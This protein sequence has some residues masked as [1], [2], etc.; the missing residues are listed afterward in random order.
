MGHWLRADFQSPGG[1]CGHCRGH[2]LVPDCLSG[3]DRSGKTPSGV[4]F[5]CILFKKVPFTPIGFVLT[6]IDYF[7]ITTTN[8]K[9][10]LGNCE[11]N[12]WRALCVFVQPTLGTFLK[13]K[14]LYVYV[15]PP[16]LFTS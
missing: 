5:F 9:L 13:V 6:F 3:T 10:S 4:A 16:L 11:T 14:L 15:F 1:R 7:L 12:S 2:L 8:F